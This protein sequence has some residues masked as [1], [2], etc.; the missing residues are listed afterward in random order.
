MMPNVCFMDEK[1]YA[2]NKR[3]TGVMIKER[4]KEKKV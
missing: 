2:N 3:K 1:N 4:A